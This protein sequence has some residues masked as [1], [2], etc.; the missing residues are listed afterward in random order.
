MWPTVSVRVHASVFD[1]PLQF[2]GW[3]GSVPRGQKLGP[4]GLGMIEEMILDAFVFVCLCVRVSVSVRV[5]VCVFV[6]KHAYNHIIVIRISSLALRRRCKPCFASGQDA[7]TFMHVCNRYHPAHEQ[8]AHVEWLALEH[9]QCP[10]AFNAHRTTDG[11]MK[12]KD[13]W[14]FSGRAS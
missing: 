12:E 4:S 14:T 6:C 11:S 13:F 7:A 10:R 1:L 8:T 5:C 9:G 3:R 2:E